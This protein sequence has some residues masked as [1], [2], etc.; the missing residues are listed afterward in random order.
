[1][2]AR[3][4]RLAEGGIGR[5]RGIY[6]L[7]AKA[8]GVSVTARPEPLGH[9]K[10]RPLH[11]WGGGASPRLTAPARRFLSRLFALRAPPN[12]VSCPGCRLPSSPGPRSSSFLVLLVPRIPVSRPSR[13][14]GFTSSPGVS[15]SRFGSP[16]VVPVFS[17]DSF[18]TPVRLT[19]QGFSASNF[20]ILWASTSHPQF[21]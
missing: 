19:A 2:A 11:V 12:P 4:R 6:A 18:S 13:L 15:P 21:G 20:K 1:R 16:S 14:R 3:R 9:N 7:S 5:R 8:V 10:T 17:G